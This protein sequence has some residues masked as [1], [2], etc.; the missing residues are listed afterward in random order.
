MSD[1][2]ELTFW[3]HLDE[4][5]KVLIRVLCVWFVLGVGYFI[6]MPYLFDKVVLAPCNND[7]SSTTCC[8]TSANASS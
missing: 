7:L 4:L 2:K 1:D 5:R 3:D 8:A 6:A